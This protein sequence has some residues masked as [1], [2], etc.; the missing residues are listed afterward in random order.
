[1]RL[2][3]ITIFAMS[4][5]ASDPIPVTDKARADYWEAQANQFAAQLKEA[6]GQLAV[7]ESRAV[8]PKL[9][10]SLNLKIAALCDDKHTPAVEGGVML[11][12]SKPVESA[13][14]Q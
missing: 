3:L 11:C 7:C 14:K 2:I 13:G 8:S 5:W 9:A 6:Q 12:K 1:M 10:E 4:C